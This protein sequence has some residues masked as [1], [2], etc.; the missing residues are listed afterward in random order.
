MSANRNDL[1]RLSRPASPP[2]AN[3]GDQEP[4][5]P[6]PTVGAPAAGRPPAQLPAAPPS[7]ATAAIVADLR[8][9]LSLSP[10]EEAAAGPARGVEASPREIAAAVRDILSPRPEVQDGRTGAGAAVEG[11]YQGKSGKSPS[12]S[13]K[14][15]RSP[16]V[17]S[18]MG[19]IRPYA[20]SL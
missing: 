11:K 14:R 13:R 15:P 12:V 7:A 6:Q 19:G 9:M 2:G 10:Q 16:S 4:A 17:P 5:A 18:L 8:S 20:P 3:W 1:G